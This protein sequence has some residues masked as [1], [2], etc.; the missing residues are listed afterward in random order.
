MAQ[1]RNATLGE[2]I[3]SRIDDNQYLQEIYEIILFNYSMH[4]LH[5][6]HRNKP[7]NRDH[8]LRF[9]DILSKSAGHPNSEKHRTW[10]QE[11]IA[12]LNSL[13]PNDAKVKAYASSVLS[14]IGNYRG[15][16]LIKS[17]YK[18][19]SLLD[20]LF[21][22]FDLDYLSIPYQEDKYFFHKQK[23]IYEHLEDETFSYSGPTSMG[24]SLLMRMFIKD[25]I[26]NGYKGN[27]AIL[28][29][30]KALITEISSSIMQEDLKDELA[31]N[32][33]KVV[34][35]GNSAFLKQDGSNYIM[36]VTPERMLYTLMSF[37][38]LSID[39]CFIDEAHKIT[40]G[41]G[42]SAFYYKVTDM[43]VQRDRK[44]HIILASPNIPN[45]NE[46]FKALPYEQ[47]ENTQ[48]LTTS[49]TPVSQ[50]KY[51]VDII[52]GEF[53][54]Y[55]GKSKSKDPFIKIGLL[56]KGIKEFDAI[57]IIISQDPSKSNIIYCNGKNRTVEL[58]R[59]YAAGLPTLNNDKLEELAKEIK[60]EIH[61]SYFL[62]ELIKKGVAY[63][64][65]YLPL[66]I[67][68]AIETY[69]R[70]GLIKTL[71]CTSTLI[72][73]VNLPADNL[74]VLSYS[75]GNHT[76][77]SVEF[78]NLLGRVGRIKYNLYGNVFII[79]HGRQAEKTIKDLL[80]KEVPAQE[81]SLKTSL[82]NYQKEYIVNCLI[83]GSSQFNQLQNQDAHSYDLMRKVGLILLR[84]I[85]KERQSVIKEEFKE[86]LDDD[87]ISLIKSHF[88]NSSDDKPKP[89]DDINIS[90]DQTQNLIVKIKQGLKYPTLVNDK[91]NYNDLVDFLNKLFHI[92][93]WDIYEKGTIG[94]LGRIRYY[95]NILVRWMNGHGLKQILD[96]TLNYNLTNRKDVNINGT[97]IEY[98]DSP[99]HRNVVIGDTLGIIENVILFSIANYFLKFSTEYK[100]LIT[101]G[102][103][104]ENDWYEYVEFGSTNELT[105][106][107]QRNGL[108]RDTAE[109]IREH[110]D[111]YVEKQ[112][113]TYKLKKSLL[114]C[115]KKS[116][117]EE[118]QDIM[119]NV[120]EL[121][122][123]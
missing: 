97:L 6:E 121:F 2:L 45:P 68:S 123:D 115:G 85:V 19:T 100:R 9:A 46:F 14:N 113:N 23:E 77:T 21:I 65:G 59:E 16:Q 81:I 48:Y 92:F 28:V 47:Q 27:F 50:M 20:E 63:H 119:Y 29:P 8:A 105:I 52:K 33:Y 64:V 76:M 60:D 22:N 36:V 103:A 58:A 94:D 51:I 110:K 24:K 93:K 75:R 69:Y 111:K 38:A 78:R 34:T 17:R 11:I 88:L 57:K 53:S 107:F 71:F 67:R 89:D 120:P 83:H 87:K 41:D 118:L 30:T 82:N 54:I 104:F 62:I 72:E 55:N 4:L 73:G 39:Y 109:Y 80:Q 108:T 35:S 114:E 26:L 106:F 86:H 99:L 66:H 40:E 70:E 74:F 44:P 102:A 18:N 112:N 31:R 96:N 13:Y 90:L 116:V 98:D 79:R 117:E 43:M 122:I 37:P 95:A 1:P 49:F 25:K 42:R 91:V 12:L 7:I 101:N 15:L 61:D 3:Y 84:D 10:A 56:N 32:N 5:Q